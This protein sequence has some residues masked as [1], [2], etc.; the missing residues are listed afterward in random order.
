MHHMNNSLM[1]FVLDDSMHYQNLK[2]I[3]NLE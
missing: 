1:K 3:K 2:G